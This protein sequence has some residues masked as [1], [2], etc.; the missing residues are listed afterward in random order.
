MTKPLVDPRIEFAK[1]KLFKH[2]YGFYSGYTVGTP[3]A[4]FNE[5]NTPVENNEAFLTMLYWRDQ[6][7]ANNRIR[8]KFPYKIYVCSQIRPTSKISRSRLELMPG[9]CRDCPVRRRT[10]V[11]CPL[12][13]LLE[14]QSEWKQ[15]ALLTG[16]RVIE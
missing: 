15:A 7:L 1:S 2:L 16:F 8:A 11:S 5:G 9:K 14:Q 4:N 10:H 6:Y 13:I 3:V 12:Q